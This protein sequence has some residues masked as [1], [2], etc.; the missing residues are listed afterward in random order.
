[1]TDL[2]EKHAKFLGYF[3][4][5]SSVIL[6]IYNYIDTNNYLKK[7]GSEALIWDILSDTI[8]VHIVTVFLGL[9]AFKLRKG[10]EAGHPKAFLLWNLLCIFLLGDSIYLLVVKFHFLFLMKSILFAY[11]TAYALLKTLNK[12]SLNDQIQN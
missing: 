7:M 3:L 4:I 6:F 12:K 1:M 10:L 11:I 2:R 9:F 8:S 5:I